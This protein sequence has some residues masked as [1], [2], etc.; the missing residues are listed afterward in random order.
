MY[1][2]FKWNN[3]PEVCGCSTVFWPIS[4]PHSMAWARARSGK[5]RT[6]VVSVWL[7]KNLIDF[8]C[9]CMSDHCCFLVLAVKFLWTMQK[10]P[11]QP[12][13]PKL[14]LLYPLSLYS[15]AKTLHCRKNWCKTQWVQIWCGSKTSEADKARN[16]GSAVF[17][18]APHILECP[19]KQICVT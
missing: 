4:Y 7:I 13:F 9:M 18:H 12:Y 11:N 16:E 17:N 15:C 6:S 19:V 3:H 1:I 5:K 2:T 10:Y 14:L 8:P